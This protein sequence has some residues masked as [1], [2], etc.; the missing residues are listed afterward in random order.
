MGKPQLLLGKKKKTLHP[1]PILE[2]PF[3]STSSAIL[4]MP[5]LPPLYSQ[6]CLKLLHALAILDIGEILSQIS[7][8][9]EDSSFRKI[10]TFQ[11]S[12]L[13]EKE[14]SQ[15]NSFCRKPRSY[16]SPNSPKST[17]ESVKFV[18][19]SHSSKGTVLHPHSKQV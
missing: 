19:F 1:S 8:S 4:L 2:P 10:K 9:E 15:W 12:N 18:F 14:Y 13:G 6:T 11:T 3:H 7:T 16:P 17:Y 5:E